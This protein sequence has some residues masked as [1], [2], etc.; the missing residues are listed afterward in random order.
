[1]VIRGVGN[2]SDGLQYLESTSWARAPFETLQP[3][4]INSQFFGDFNHFCHPEFTPS[5]RRSLYTTRRLNSS[6]SP[7][8]RWT[9]GSSARC[10]SMASRRGETPLSPPS[11]PSSRPH[12]IAYPS[13]NTT[14]V[15]RGA[16]R[17]QLFIFIFS[18]RPFTLSYQRT[19]RYSTARAEYFRD[20]H[21]INLTFDCWLD[22]FLEFR[23]G[24]SYTSHNQSHKV[25]EELNND[26]H[27]SSDT[28]IIRSIEFILTT[29]FPSLCAQGPLR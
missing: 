23:I 11:A 10:L 12:S 16:S 3:D 26:I 17:L 18:H 19:P 6:P 21:F 13:L 14:R 7:R 27:D 24:R 28:K 22:F 8:T 1:M 29:Y 15:Y 4:S 2:G 5:G 9:S 25:H 20:D